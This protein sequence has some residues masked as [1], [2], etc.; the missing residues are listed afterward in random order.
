[1]SGPG[2]GRRR[3]RAAIVTCQIST[4]DEYV[5][6]T[7]RRVSEQFGIRPPKP[8][9]TAVHT[10]ERLNL[11]SNVVASLCLRRKCGHSEDA[12]S[13]AVR[14][15]PAIRAQA[16]RRLVVG[17]LPHQYQSPL[18]CFAVEDLPDSHHCSVSTV[19]HTRVAQLA[20]QIR[21]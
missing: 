2:G 20:T 7:S 6:A 11:E 3:E 14:Q 18:A 15:Y 9:A 5:E 12:C 10:T 17:A 1:M 16:S 21:F 13:G 19:P 8:D 4:S